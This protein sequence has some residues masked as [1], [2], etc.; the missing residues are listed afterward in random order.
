MTKDTVSNVCVKTVVDTRIITCTL[1]FD[2]SLAQ[3]WNR[4]NYLFCLLQS[5]LSYKQK[6]DTSFF[7]K[8][9]KL[10]R[11]KIMKNIQCTLSTFEKKYGK[12]MLREVSREMWMKVPC[13][14]LAKLFSLVCSAD[15]TSRT[16]CQ[17]IQDIF[18]VGFSTTLC[19]TLCK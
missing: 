12:I 15:Y 18:N 8:Q 10:Y 19:Y 1:T 16:S 6:L 2:G 17:R 13:L 5:N 14:S 3:N 9:R 4:L 7:F 11:V